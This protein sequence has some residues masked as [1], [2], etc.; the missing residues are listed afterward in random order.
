MFMGL[1]TL[2]AGGEGDEEERSEGADLGLH[3]AW[4]S[5]GVGAGGEGRWRPSGAEEIMAGVTQ[6]AGS[7]HM[8]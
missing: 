6:G 3:A 5:G 2:A 4:T 1:N 7:T 8:N